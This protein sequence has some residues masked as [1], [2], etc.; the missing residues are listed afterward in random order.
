MNCRKGR[1]FPL[2]QKLYLDTKGIFLPFD[3]TALSFSDAV[4]PKQNANVVFWSR[5]NFLELRLTLALQ[6]FVSFI[7]QKASVSKVATVT[8][9]AAM[10]I[11]Y[12]PWDKTKTDWSGGGVHLSAADVNKAKPRPGRELENTHGS[13][14]YSCQLTACDSIWLL[15]DVIFLHGLR[16]RNGHFTKAPRTVSFSHR[17]N[18]AAAGEEAGLCLWWLRSEVFM[19]S[20]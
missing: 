3:E 2:F 14:C 11:P 10:L 4:Q 19:A 8:A 5:K 12:V 13:V 17:N 20:D 7:S 6:L 15:W 1:C 16:R 9:A 18:K